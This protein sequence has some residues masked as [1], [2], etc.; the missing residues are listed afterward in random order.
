[1]VVTFF[2]LIFLVAPLSLLIHEMGHALTALLHQAEHSSITIGRGS[3]LFSV[4]LGRVKVH[5]RWVFFQGAQTLNERKNPFSLREKAWI[6]IGGP[7]FNAIV[8]WFFIAM[9]F[10][11]TSRTWMLFGLFNGYLALVNSIP[12]C[13]RG[14]KSDGYR[15]LEGFR[16]GSILR[17]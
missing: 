10:L 6:S 11:S 3:K 17:G 16:W 9:P 14:K 5:I 8:A 12:F 13:F 1:M 4:K 7:L 2:I 15:F